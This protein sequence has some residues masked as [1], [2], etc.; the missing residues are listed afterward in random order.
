MANS[1]KD[2]CIRNLQVSSWLKMRV[3]TSQKGKLLCY[4]NLILPPT[5][6]TIKHL[7]SL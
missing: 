3:P 5:H 1:A 4:K 6:A 2:N 7:K